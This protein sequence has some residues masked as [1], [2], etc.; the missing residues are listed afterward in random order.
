MKLVDTSLWIH[1]MR[2]TGDATLRKRV[3]DLLIAGEAAWCPLVR[4]ELWAGVGNDRE[5]NMLRQYEEIIP[6]YPIDNE[7]WQQACELATRCRR[8][9]KTVPATDLLIAA[10]ARRHKADLEHADRHFDIIAK[11]CA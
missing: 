9:G 6:G 2:R 3:N 1:Q 4:L 10:C 8:A 7:V 11:A 5:R